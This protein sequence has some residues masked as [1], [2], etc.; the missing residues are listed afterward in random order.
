MDGGG[1]I[2]CHNRFTRTVYMSENMFTI[3][4]ENDRIKNIRTFIKD[5]IHGIILSSIGII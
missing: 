1:T 3:Q 5:K 2:I 4:Y